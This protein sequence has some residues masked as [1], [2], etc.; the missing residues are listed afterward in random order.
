MNINFIAVFIILIVI[1]LLIHIIRYFYQ[2][3]NERILESFKDNAIQIKSA[4]YGYNNCGSNGSNQTSNLSAACNDKSSCS[5]SIDHTRIGDPAPECPKQY[6][7]TWCC[8]SECKNVVEAGEASGKTIN[9]RCEPPS[10]PAPNITYENSGSVYSMGTTGI[11]PWGDCPGFLDQSAQWIWFQ[12]GTK[13]IYS[14]GSKK[15]KSNRA[16]A[17]SGGVFYYNWNNDTNDYINIKINIIAD[18]GC[19]IWVNSKY[20]GFQEGGAG[21]AGGIIT[22]TLIPGINNFQFRA[23]NYKDDFIVK[24][25]FEQYN[26]AGILV[27]VL[28]QDNNQILF[29]SNSDWKYELITSNTSF[30]PRSCLN[31][32]IM[33]YTNYCTGEVNGP[34]YIKS[35]L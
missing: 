17:N 8:N 35:S 12:D 1:Y 6:N 34:I 25:R 11:D 15:W 9:L 26:P 19:Q 10:P 23:Q 13:P 24:G 33:R 29:N 30:T 20:K 27:S 22:A 31:F 2:N 3:K 18:A 16:P 14:N 32:Y 21:G 7:Y 5:Y 4:T 28:R